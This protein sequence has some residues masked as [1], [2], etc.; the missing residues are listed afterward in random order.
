M[1]LYMCPERKQTREEV[2]YSGKGKSGACQLGVRRTFHTV[3]AEQRLKT[4][5]MGGKY[6]LLRTS[7]AVHR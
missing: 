5:T 7:P 6:E 3:Y 2:H 4:K 1:C